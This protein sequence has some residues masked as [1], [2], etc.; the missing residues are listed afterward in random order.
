M[1]ILICTSF[2][3]VL[4]CVNTKKNITNE[5]LNTLLSKTN[6]QYFETKKKNI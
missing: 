2:L 4:S 3:F 1:K 6:M 5:E